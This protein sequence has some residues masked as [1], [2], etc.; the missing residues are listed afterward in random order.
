MGRVV[1]VTDPEEAVR[2]FEAGMLYWHYAEGVVPLGQAWAPH[3]IR[4][5]I[6][7]YPSRHCLVYIVEDEEGDSP[8]TESED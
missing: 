8:T 1:R 6:K 5:D 7:F 3:N 2:L 4:D